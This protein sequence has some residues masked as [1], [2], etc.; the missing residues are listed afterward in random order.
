MS[1]LCQNT[2]ARPYKPTSSH[3]YIAAGQNH[4]NRQTANHMT[5]SFTS[6][7]SES[8]LTPLKLGHNGS[9]TNFDAR[10]L[11]PS[12]NLPKG[13]ICPFPESGVASLK[14]L[15]NHSGPRREHSTRGWTCKREMEMKKRVL[16]KT[17]PLD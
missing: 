10:G 8:E 14:G 16:S 15:Q 3:T 12:L 11:P 17:I 9:K 4:G 5:S 1:T 2:N 6:S 7:P 13:E